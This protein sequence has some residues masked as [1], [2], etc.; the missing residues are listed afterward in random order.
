[1]PTRPAVLAAVALW[2]A[3]PPAT[4]ASRAEDTPCFVTAG[5]RHPLS[6][7][8][9][10]TSGGGGGDRTSL[11]GCS[12]RCV[13]D[14]RR[15]RFAVFIIHRSGAGCFCTNSIKKVGF[16]APNREACRD[17]SLSVRFVTDV[18]N[19]TLESLGCSSE[20]PARRTVRVNL[21]LLLRK[22]TVSVSRPGTNTASVGAEVSLLGLR[23]AGS[24]LGPAPPAAAVSPRQRMHRR[25]RAEVAGSRLPTAFTVSPLGRLSAFRRKRASLLN[26]KD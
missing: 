11:S 15:H 16:A 20:L 2:L 8:A 19:Q 10:V 17:S 26:K 18:S 23:L 9:N 25:V 6:G 14:S 4:G 22:R 21:P 12:C 5:T 24:S 7:L 3:I 13:A 1:M